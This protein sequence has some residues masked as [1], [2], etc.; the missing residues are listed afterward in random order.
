M[1]DVRIRLACRDFA[2]ATHVTLRGFGKKNGV[3]AV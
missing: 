3:R 1:L 2:I